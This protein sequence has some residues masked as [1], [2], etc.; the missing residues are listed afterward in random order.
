MNATLRII[1]VDSNGRS[2][3]FLGITPVVP[4]EIK[5]LGTPMSES[6]LAAAL[7]ALERGGND[8]TNPDGGSHVRFHITLKP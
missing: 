3:A 4:L 8:M 5:P 7:L 1:R 6:A 2:E